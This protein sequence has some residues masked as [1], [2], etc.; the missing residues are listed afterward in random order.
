LGAAAPLRFRADPELFQ[1][2]MLNVVQNA[3]EATSRGG[4]I[5]LSTVGVDASVEFRV[6][7]TGRG[8]EAETLARVFDPFFT[9]RERG[10]GLGLS[11]SH[12]LAEAQGAGLEIASAPGRGTAVTLSF[13]AESGARVESGDAA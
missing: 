8:M 9:T 1:Q 10:T 2:I 12:R 6:E 7:D 11:I 13:P 5:A 3:L 4:S